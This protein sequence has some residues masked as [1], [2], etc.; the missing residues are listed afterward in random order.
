[1]TSSV[2]AVQTFEIVHLKVALV[3]VARVTKLTGLFGEAILGAPAIT[4]HVPV[5]P[6]PTALAAI[7]THP[8]LHNV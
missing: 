5:S 1:M 2:D 6:V 7:G 4:V 8:A 3:P